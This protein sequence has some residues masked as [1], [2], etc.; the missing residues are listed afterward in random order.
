MEPWASSTPRRPVRRWASSGSSRWSTRPPATCPTPPASCSTG[1]AT[2]LRRAAQ[3]AQGAAAQHR[4]GG[5]RGLRDGGRARWPTSPARCGW[6]GRSPTSSASTCTPRAPTRSR[7]GPRQLLTPGHR[8]EELIER[9]QWWG[10]QMLIWGVHVHVGVRHRDARDAGR[11]LAAQLL[12]APAGAVRV[13]ADVVG[14]R[15]RLRQQPGDDVPAAARPPGC[16]SSSRPGR[17]TRT[18]SRTTSA[19]A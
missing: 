1:S 13:L 7:S 16:P 3:A 12:P 6:C 5:H 2:S 9:T 14:H 8:Y 18:S 15:H 11:L 19:P 4:R 10:R 17:S